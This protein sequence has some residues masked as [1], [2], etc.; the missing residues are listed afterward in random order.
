[1]DATRQLPEEGGPKQY[2]LMNRACLTKEFPDIFEFIDEKW[3]E[4]IDS[5]NPKK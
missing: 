2:S 4:T 1:V 5:W 3:S